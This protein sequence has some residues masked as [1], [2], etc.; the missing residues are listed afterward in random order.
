MEFSNPSQIPDSTLN[1]S[2]HLEPVTLIQESH[3][4]FTDCVI[5]ID[6]T[7]ETDLPE[8]SSSSCKIWTWKAAC[9]AAIW[10]AICSENC[11]RSCSKTE[12][13]SIPVPSPAEEVPDFEFE[14]VSVAVDSKIVNLVK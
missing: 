4:S 3:E 7:L 13:S 1:N 2:N 14:R 9:E 6:G 10:E 11:S 12:C 5:S 8:G